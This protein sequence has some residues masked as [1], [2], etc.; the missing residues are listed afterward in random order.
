MLQCAPSVCMLT[1]TYL[2]IHSIIPIY[3]HIMMRSNTSHILCLCTT[4][5]CFQSPKPCSHTTVTLIFDKN[6]QNWTS[7]WH[8]IWQKYSTNRLNKFVFRTAI[9][10]T[11]LILIIIYQFLKILINIYTRCKFE[12]WFHYFFAKKSC[13][14]KLDCLVAR[15]RKCIPRSP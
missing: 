15:N 12:S 7:F 1:G 4:S 11:M 13:Q 3:R 10:C 6:S 5:V 9:L 8:K 14:L 2:Y